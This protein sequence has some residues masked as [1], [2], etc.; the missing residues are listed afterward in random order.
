ML[1]NDTIRSTSSRCQLVS[2]RTCSLMVFWDLTSNF[3]STRDHN[4]IVVVQ[5]INIMMRWVLK[6]LL[7]SL[8]IE[9]QFQ[10]ELTPLIKFA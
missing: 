2:T 6:K 10:Q 8:V 5:V 7:R 9:D 3:T 1:I 4:S